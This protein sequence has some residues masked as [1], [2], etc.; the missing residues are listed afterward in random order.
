MGSDY[1]ACRA[2]LNGV[3][4]SSQLEPCS[5]KFKEHYSKIVLLSSRFCDPGVDFS[6]TPG[7]AF[8]RHVLIGLSNS[9]NLSR[10][11]KFVT[12]NPSLAKL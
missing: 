6:A 1:K 10:F 3:C 5:E 4:H 2:D 9:T 11:P 7:L 8:L 12:E